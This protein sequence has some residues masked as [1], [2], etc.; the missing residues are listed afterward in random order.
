[1]E[2]LTLA[3]VVGFIQS[4]GFP[5]AVASYVLV[6]MNRSL[7]ELTSAI[8]AVHALL[9]LHLEEGRRNGRH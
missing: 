6:V 3:A 4:V 5:V 9:A 7:R 2:G 8:Q 1:M